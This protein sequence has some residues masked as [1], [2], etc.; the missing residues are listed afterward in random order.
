MLIRSGSA[1]LRAQVG[2]AGPCR[3]GSELSC[4]AA[5]F[6]EHAF[7]GCSAIKSRRPAALLPAS[8]PRSYRRTRQALPSHDTGRAEPFDASRRIAQPPVFALDCDQG[9]HAGR[10]SPSQSCSTDEVQMLFAIEQLHKAGFVSRDVKPS[11]FTGWSIGGCLQCPT[12]RRLVGSS[13]DSR[14]LIYM[15]DFGISKHYRDANGE[16]IPPG[17]GVYRGTTRYCSINSHKG[18]VSCAANAY[19]SRR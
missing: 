11:N 10:P 6:S 1:V 4:Y 7:S 16:I 13:C 2:K 17:K 12:L 9:V 19:G 18:V 8:R 15:L 3:H 5:G 14:R